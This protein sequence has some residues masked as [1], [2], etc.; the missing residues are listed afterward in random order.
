MTGSSESSD[1]EISETSP[2]KST[3]GVD[4]EKLAARVYQLMIGEVRLEL[5]RGGR[6]I[7]RRES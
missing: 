1:R 6:V 2:A 3:G 5:A 4:V 7:N